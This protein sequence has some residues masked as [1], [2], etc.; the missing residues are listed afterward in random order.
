MIIYDIH[1]E[2]T[3]SNIDYT[4]IQSAIDLYGESILGIFILTI[5]LFTKKKNGIENSNQINR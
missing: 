4:V 5:G 3:A 1:L 2:N